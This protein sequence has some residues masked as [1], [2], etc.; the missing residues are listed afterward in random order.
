M[1][2]LRQLFDELNEQNKTM[3][4]KYLFDDTSKLKTTYDRLTVRFQDLEIK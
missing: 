4:D 1:K 3:L 2:Q